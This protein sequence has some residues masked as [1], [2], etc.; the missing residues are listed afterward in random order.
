MN[1]SKIKIRLEDLGI[2]LEAIAD[3]G[4]KEAIVLL[5]NLVEELSSTIRELQE[6]NQKLRDE[7][8]KLKGEQGKPDIR[9]QKGKE[10]TDFSSEKERK[11]KEGKKKG[12]RGPKLNKL[13][14]TRIEECKV[15]KEELPSDAEFKGHDSVIVQDIKIETENIEFKK[16]VYYSPSCGKTYTGKIPA[17]YEG[18]YGPSVKS[19]TI[20]MKY[21]CNMSEPKI[22]EF[23]THFGVDISSSTISRM[24]NK[25]NDIFHEEKKEIFQ[26]GLSSSVYQ[27]IDDT[28]ARVNGENYYTHVVCN[29][30]YTA[31]FTEKHKDRLTIL[32]ILRG[33]S[34][35]SYLFNEEAFELLDKLRVSEGIREKVRSFTEG[36]V[37]K[38]EELTEVLLKNMPKIGKITKARIFE[39]GAISSYQNERGY[40]VVEVLVCDDAPQFKLLTENLGLCW[41]HDGRHY[42]KLSPVV[43]HH[44]KELERFRKTYW[45]YYKKLLKYKEAPSKEF[46]CELSEEFDKI[47]STVT[48]YDNLDERI[49]LSKDKKEELLM[50]LK[51][52]EIP[53][54]NN[55]AELGARAQVRKRDVSLQ[56]RTPE[57]TK[58]HDTFLTIVQTAKKLLVNVYDYIFDRIS[59]KNELPSLAETITEKANQKETELCQ[60]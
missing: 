7:N 44:E 11:S 24:L 41:I 35:R 55:E 34:E 36:K 60:I 38:E 12:K 8:N 58:A 48:D 16:E 21:A 29:S 5:F 17:G 18:G 30:L 33:D 10:D 15:P 46:A 42:K 9:E 23:L 4:A 25:K 47:F 49:S 20:V 31:Y 57:G 19:L 53:L 52:P 45:D 28:S 2:N 3:S 51:Y 39:A 1:S 56:T 13:K 22:L 59:R 43:P 54:H 6:E 32:D 27:Q 14:I 50:V 26:A 40:P 37:Y